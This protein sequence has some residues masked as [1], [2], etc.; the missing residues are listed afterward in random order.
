MP[1]AEQRLGRYRTYVHHIAAISRRLG[2]Q[3]HPW[4]GTVISML[5]F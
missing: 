3:V 4:I 2:F 5:A 1:L